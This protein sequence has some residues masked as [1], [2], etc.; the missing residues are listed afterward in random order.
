MRARVLAVL[1]AGAPAPINLYIQH[2]G[3]P[4]VRFTLHVL[5]GSGV[6]ALR[7]IGRRATLFVWKEVSNGDM[8]K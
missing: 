2:V 8:V 6:F 3:P 4:T 1:Y 5:L 7:V